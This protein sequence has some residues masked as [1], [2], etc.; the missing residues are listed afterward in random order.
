ML[1]SVVSASGYFVVSASGVLNYLRA[2]VARIQCQQPTVSQERKV[3]IKVK[4][5]QKN[6]LEFVKG[7]TMENY[8]EKQ[9]NKLE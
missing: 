7:N 9:K 1:E 4:Q 6:V 3:L 8:L 2:Q 5:M